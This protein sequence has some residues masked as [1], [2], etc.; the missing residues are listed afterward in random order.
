MQRIGFEPVTKRKHDAPPLR[1]V[2]PEP[3][4]RLPE[5]RTQSSENHVIGHQ[6]DHVIDQTKQ[7]DNVWWRKQ[8]NDQCIPTS[9]FIF[10]RTKNQLV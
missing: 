8:T 4:L 2:L 5:P 6:N 1:T 7:H 10:M 3:A 9:T